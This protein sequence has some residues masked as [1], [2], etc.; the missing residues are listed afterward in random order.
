V[1]AFLD[2]HARLAAHMSKSSW[3][4]AGSHM[5]VAIDEEGGRVPGSHIRMHGTLLGLRLVLDEVVMEYLRPERKVWQ[6]V[7]TPRLLVI[8]HYRMG[9]EIAANGDSCTL[10]MFIDY[11]LPTAWPA[12]WLS[13]MFGGFYARWCTESMANGAAKHFQQQATT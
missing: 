11:T 13:R 10:R 5:D 8:G 1:F 7:G 9:F 12:R 3:M 2:D 4:M 6:T